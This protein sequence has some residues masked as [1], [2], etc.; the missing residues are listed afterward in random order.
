LFGDCPAWLEPA[1]LA[2][3][4]DLHLLLSPEQVEWT[5]D[6]Q[7]C[8]PELSERLAFFTST[9]TWLEQHCQPFQIIQGSWTQ[10]RFQAIEAVS[11]LLDC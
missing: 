5:D 8:Q 6:G 3:H 7:R 4:Y 10:R 9:Q 2:R 11:H 1:L